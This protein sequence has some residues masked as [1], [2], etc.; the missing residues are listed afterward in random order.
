MFVTGVV[1]SFR[2]EAGPV[3][4]ET[5]NEH[6]GMFVDPDFSADDSSLFCDC[7]TPLPKLLGDVTWLRPQVTFCHTGNIM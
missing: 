2:R 1:A 4:M 6:H 7:T 5:E 3:A